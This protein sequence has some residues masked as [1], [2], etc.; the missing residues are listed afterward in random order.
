MTGVQTCALPISG[1]QAGDED[2]GE[3]A[4]LHEGPGC[5]GLRAWG[6][7]RLVP[8]R[9]VRRRREISLRL[10]AVLCGETESNCY[11][12]TDSVT[13]TAAGTSSY[14]SYPIAQILTVNQPRG[15]FSGSGVASHV[16]VWRRI[17]P[18][19]CIRF[20]N[21]THTR[22]KRAY[23]SLFGLLSGNPVRRPE[24]FRIQTDG[25]GR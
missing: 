7:R 1:S 11:L 5:T 13:S 8:G 14:N 25:D 4:G 15:I 22:Y 18:T 10:L 20:I 23:F 12:Y 3:P 6:G 17:A 19:N 2:A 21:S 9:L 16:G 24:G